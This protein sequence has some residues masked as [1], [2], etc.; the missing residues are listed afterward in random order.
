MGLYASIDDSAV[1]GTALRFSVHPIDSNHPRIDL[2]I[3]LTILWDR[4][5]IDVDPRIFAIWNND[6]TKTLT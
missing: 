3:D 1:G 6:H 5:L 4:Y 2:Y